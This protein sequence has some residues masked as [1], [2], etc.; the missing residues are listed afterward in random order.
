MQTEEVGTP[1]TENVQQTTN[2][3]S[4]ALITLNDGLVNTEQYSPDGCMAQTA[5]DTKA[6][7]C[8]FIIGHNHSET[9]PD[10][11]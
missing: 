8:Q 9:L 10:L 5:T 11:T 4:I 2:H 1:Y 6:H 7:R 3:H